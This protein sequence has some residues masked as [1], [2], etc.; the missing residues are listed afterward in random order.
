[1]RFKKYNIVTDNPYRNLDDERT[2]GGNTSNNML[3]L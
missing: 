3:V 1:M 2:E